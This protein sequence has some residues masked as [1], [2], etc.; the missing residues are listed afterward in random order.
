ML[1]ELLMFA[2]LLFKK[3]TASIP[4]N[5]RI[6]MI[7]SVVFISIKKLYESYIN[8]LLMVLRLSYSFVL[9]YIILREELSHQL[10]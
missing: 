7:K 5:T 2:I 1:F 6:A 3:L 10:P 4:A 8:H 9:Q